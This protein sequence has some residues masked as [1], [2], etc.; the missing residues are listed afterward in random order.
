LAPLCG[1][2]A[3]ALSCDAAFAKQGLGYGGSHLKV[4]GQFNILLMI[5]V[6]DFPH[7]TTY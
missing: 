2:S 1:A 5:D 3:E 6:A 7:K 4:T